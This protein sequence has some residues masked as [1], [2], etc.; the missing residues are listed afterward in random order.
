MFSGLARPRTGL[1]L[2]V[3]SLMAHDAAFAPRSGSPSNTPTTS[4]PL[5]LERNDGEHRTWRPIEGA[6]GFDAVPGPFTLKIDPHNG[7]STHLVFGTEDLPRGAK[8]DQH[9]HPDSDEIIYLQNGSAHVTVG[10]AARDVHAGATVFIPAN[11]WIT[12]TNM[13]GE[14][15]HMVFIF[16]APGFDNFMRAESVPEGQPAT[17]LSKAQDAAIQKQ[18][19]HAVIYHP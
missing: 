17:P 9:K 3:V 1:V 19:E 14:P 4:T 5:I 12:V 10:V 8:I 16:S 2:A 6:T 11:T 7:G 18:F 15:I 13:G